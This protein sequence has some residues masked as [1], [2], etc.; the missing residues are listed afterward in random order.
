MHYLHMQE[1]YRMCMI[2]CVLRIPVH[3]AVYIV[4]V[5]HC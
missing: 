1:C 4:I 5:L 3:K 2:P